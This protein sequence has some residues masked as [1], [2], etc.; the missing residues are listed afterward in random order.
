M[1]TEDYNS[2]VH[3]YPFFI[4]QKKDIIVELP[5]VR[6]PRAN[7]LFRLYSSCDI[8]EGFLNEEYSLKR[9]LA[10]SHIFNVA[11][12]NGGCVDFCTVLH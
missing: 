6:R 8:S 5:P 9:A 11:C 3:L 4:Q 12:L 10:L 7:A 1:I 2:A